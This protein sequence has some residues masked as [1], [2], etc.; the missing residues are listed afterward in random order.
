[1]ANEEIVP[2]LHVMVRRFKDIDDVEF[3]V[4]I[5]P[6]IEGIVQVE[7]EEVKRWL[8]MALATGWG[9]AFDEVAK[10]ATEWRGRATAKVEGL[11][12][13]GVELTN[14]D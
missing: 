2:K 7:I 9:A 3:V 12:G 6:S 13:V 10:R 11:E 14:Y 4:E 8:K 5:S 1:M